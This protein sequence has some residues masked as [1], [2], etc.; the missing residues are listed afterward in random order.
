MERLERGWRKESEGESDII[1]FYL[2]MYKNFTQGNPK[3]TAV[4]KKTLFMKVF[5]MLCS[6]LQT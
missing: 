3:F 6:I 5:F 4:K 2:K 1:M